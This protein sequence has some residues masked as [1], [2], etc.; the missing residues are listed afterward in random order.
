MPDEISRIALRPSIFDM[1]SAVS[2]SASNML[3]SE[4][5]GMRSRDSAS[6]VFARSLVKSLRMVG[7]QVVGDHRHVIVR[8]QALHESI[9][10]GQ[11]LAPPRRVIGLVS[12][13]ELDHHGHGQ[14]AL[15]RSET[16]SASAG[17]CLP[18]C[19]TCLSGDAR[20]RIA[21]VVEHL[22]IHVDDVGLG[23]ES[24]RPLRPRCPSSLWD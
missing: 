16:A 6:I 15:R 14:R 20:N 13:A 23:F 22:H 4:K 10:R 12:R 1:R 9:G 7:L 2:A 8:L 11:R 19:G 3:L 21:V 17:H 5:P 24:S 18:E